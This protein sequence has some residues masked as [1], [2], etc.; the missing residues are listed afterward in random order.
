MSKF[1]SASNFNIAVVG[2][3]RDLDIFENKTSLKHI[4]YK[5][6]TPYMRLRLKISKLLVVTYVKMKKSHKWLINTQ[7]LLG[8]KF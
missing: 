8:I 7:Y 3:D 4:Q 5:G 2:L 1:G 6:N